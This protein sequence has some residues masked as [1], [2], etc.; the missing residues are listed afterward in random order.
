MDIVWKSNPSGESSGS[1][2]EE[3]VIM[4]QKV[5]KWCPDEQVIRKNNIK[6]SWEDD[7]LVEG[8]GDATEEEEKDSGEDQ[9]KE[10]ML[11]RDSGDTLVTKESID[12]S[13]KAYAP[14][15]LDSEKSVK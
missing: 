1:E 9:S 5:W 10:A 6:E 3:Q 14:T 12:T 13:N 7:S 15:S 4:G 11:S 8:N 2:N